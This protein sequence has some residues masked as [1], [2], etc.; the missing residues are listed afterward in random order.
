MGDVGD[1]LV[2]RGIGE[3]PERAA[4]RRTIPGPRHA[5]AFSLNATAIDFSRTISAEL[6]KPLE[7]MPSAFL[8]WTITASNQVVQSRKRKDA[9]ALSPRSRRWWRRQTPVGLKHV[10]RLRLH[11]PSLT[12][13]PLACLPLL[14]GA[15]VYCSVECIYVVLSSRLR[16]TV[17]P[18][19]VVWRRCCRESCR[20]HTVVRTE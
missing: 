7:F 19:K 13:S 6:A 4:S 11:F 2:S 5:I 18:L 8:L 16:R 12:H 9:R 20:C 10:C 17:L 3:R 14:L 15:G 1:R